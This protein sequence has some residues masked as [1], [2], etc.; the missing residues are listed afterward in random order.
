MTPV[1]YTSFCTADNALAVA[2]SHHLVVWNSRR[3]GVER[4]GQVFLLVLP[5]V[6]VLPIDHDFDPC[7]LFRSNTGHIFA[8]VGVNCSCEASFLLL[9]LT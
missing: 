9:L 1:M 8:C 4:S 6:L 2:S 5:D 3:T 7:D